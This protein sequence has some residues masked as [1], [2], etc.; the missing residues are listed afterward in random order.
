MAIPQNIKHLCSTRGAHEK[1]GCQLTS[2]TDK[3]FLVGPILDEGDCNLAKFRDNVALCFLQK[4][5]VILVFVIKDQQHYY[6]IKYDQK[7]DYIAALVQ[8]ASCLKRNC[9][10]VQLNLPSIILIFRFLPTMPLNI[11]L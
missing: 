6:F 11:N 2:G 8:N 5:K 10:V 7:I 4:G 3:Q 9:C 1:S